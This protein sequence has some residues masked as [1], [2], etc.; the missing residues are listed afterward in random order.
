MTRYILEELSMGDNNTRDDDKPPSHPNSFI[1][2]RIEDNRPT[3][4]LTLYSPER[5]H[6]IK[7]YLDKRTQDWKLTRRQCRAINDYNNSDS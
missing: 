5:G 7:W 4:Q 3:E 6:I 2:I 1:L